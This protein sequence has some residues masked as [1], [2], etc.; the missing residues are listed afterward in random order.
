MRIGEK[1]QFYIC[2]LQW[3]SETTKLWRKWILELITRH[4]LLR[5]T[6]EE[7]IN[8]FSATD[9][10]WW[11]WWRVHHWEDHHWWPP[12]PRPSPIGSS[13]C[14]GSKYLVSVASWAT[15]STRPVQRAAPLCQSDHSAS[16]TAAV[17]GGRHHRGSRRTED[18]SRSHLHHFC[19][20]FRTCSCCL[21]VSD[22]H[23]VK[24]KEHLD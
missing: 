24:T 15:A 6:R 2:H 4:Q 9:C 23:K 7:E 11:A 3:P 22:T 13:S 17:P 12:P 10:A 21:L 16:E 18:R 19:P 8:M 5:L 14:S 20:S 1:K